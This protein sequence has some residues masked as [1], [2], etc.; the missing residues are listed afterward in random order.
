MDVVVSDLP[1]H[2]MH[3]KL[4]TLLSASRRL[5]S[6]IELE[7]L[8][9]VIVTTITE[10]LSCVDPRAAKPFVAVNCVS[11][12]DHFLESELFGHEKGVRRTSLVSVSRWV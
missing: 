5:T 6:S 1:S 9:R 4:D 8:L 10:L 3:V 11:L 2:T 12:S 7:A